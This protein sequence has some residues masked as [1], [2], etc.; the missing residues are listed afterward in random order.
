MEDIIDI[1]VTET[2][3]L[4]EITSQPTDEIIDVNIIDNR[5][6]VT[7]NVT[8]TVV[9]ININSLT[10]NFGI[11]WGEIDGTLSN[12][13]DLQNALNLKADLVGGKVPSSQLPSYVDDVV[14]VA[15]YASLPA[16]GETGK[17]YVTIDTNYIYRWTGSVYVEIKDSSAVWGAITGTL[18]NQTDLQNALNAKLNLS[19]GTLTGGLYINPANSSTVGLD[20][21]SNTFRLRT[22][23]SEPFN[24]QLTTT[25]GS[26][27]LVKM[28]AAGYGAT[29]VT[30]LGFYTSSGSAVNT[31]PNLYLTGGDNRVGVNTTTPS[32]SLDVQGTAGVSGN[33]TAGA[34]IKSGGT[35]SQFLKA[36]GSID[37]STYATTSQLHNPVTLGTANGLTLSTQVLSLGLASSSANGAL[38]SADW[39][40]FNA[41]QAAL[42]GTGFVKIS[43]T[44]IS[45]D[46]STYLTT[47]SAASTYLPLTGGN[48]TGTTRMDGSGGTAESISMIFNTGINRLLAPVLRLF[49]STNVAS[50][51]VELYGTL[52]TQ[53]RTINFPDASGTVA[54]TSNLSSYLPLSGGTLTGAL[55][56]TSVSLSSSVTATRLILSGGTGN[57]GL[58]FGHTDRVVLANYGVGGID[59]E[60]NGGNI[61]MTLFPSGN[62]GVGASMTDAGYK[63]DVAGTGRF[64][65]ALSGTSATFS[66][67]VG[68]GVSLSSWDTSFRA[69]QISGGFAAMGNA[70]A[71]Y[72][73]GNAYFDG[74]NKYFSTAPS[75]RI[76]VGNGIIFRVAGS[77]TAGNIISYTAALSLTTT[78]AATF[79]SSVTAT[80]IS[81]V[82]KEGFIVQATTTGGGGSQPA[83]TYYTAAG[84]KRWSTF[85]NVGDDKFH[86]AGSANTELFTIQQ[87]GSVGIGTTSPSKKLHIYGTDAAQWITNTSSTNYATI[88]FLNNVG[89]NMS[90]GIGG[91]SASSFASSGYIVTGGSYP[92]ILGTNDTERMRITSGG[93]VG[94][95]TTSPIG[96]LH[97]VNASGSGQPALELQQSNSGSNILQWKGSGGS[98]LGVIGDNGNVGIGTVS[99][100]SFRLSVAGS[101]NVI[102]VSSSDNSL[103]LALGYQG[104][105]HG[106]LGG[107][108]SRLEAYSSNGGYAYLSSSSTWIPA[109]DRNR[110]RNFETYNLGLN[111]I[112]GLNPSLYNMDFQKDGD[113]KQVGLIAQEVKNFI[114]LA[115]EQSD[116]FIGINYNAIIVT[117]VN[118]IKELKA[119]LDTLKNK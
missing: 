5:E 112:L 16:T 30:D 54:L 59:F 3:N 98:Y 31:T 81:S 50:N 13:T 119:E 51:Y 64:T 70:S 44:T 43:G 83:Y 6:D 76:D 42:N 35:S 25:I 72:I 90:I 108:S 60:T 73:F 28:Q 41:K 111:E 118:A 27:T 29:Y 68:I 23:S 34:I 56:G 91:S 63:L 2:T 87:N 47:S 109:S 79:S 22:D 97:I 78:G 7:L 18:S 19:G 32:Y 107:I 37:S 24:R 1:I 116:K 110:K 82:F 106:Y 92:F 58:Y 15:N 84:S 114:P 105:M 62:L 65:G 75:S 102:G 115:Y 12:Q 101:G 85:L 61:Y 17:I 96:R 9:E 89:E 95:G 48:L 20:V 117:M 26:G 40:T 94:I 69:L 88:A 103:S 57:T 46:N 104:T 11:N 21:A 38:S 8:P 45:Y 67:N 36:D 14:E 77:G 49:G 55:S 74:D 71:G 100:G 113:E 80:S 53:N 39:T 10:G 99:P 52:A 66:G 86:I 4:I 33:L 93:N